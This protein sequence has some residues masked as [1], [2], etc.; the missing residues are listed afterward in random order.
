MTFTC[1]LATIRKHQDD[2]DDVLYED[3]DRE[4]LAAVLRAI[5]G[6]LERSDA[7]AKKI[8]CASGPIG[9]WRLTP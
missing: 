2:L 8:A 3:E 5:A 9:G 4:L 6:D 7:K 1:Q